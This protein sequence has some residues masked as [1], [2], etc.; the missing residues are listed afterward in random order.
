VS[1]L[2]A[3][4]VCLLGWS[5]GPSGAGRA[6]EQEASD[7]GQ[8]TITVAGD[9]LPESSWQGPNNAA[10]LFDGVREEFQRAD[11]VFVNLEEP[12][13]RS[14]QV[15]PYKS[16]AAVKA[17][18][19]YVLHAQN[20][21][22]FGIFKDSGI[23]LV[24][25]AN[26]HM[27]DYTTGGLEDTL[28]GFDRVGMPVVGAG[29]KRQAE[30][31]YVFRKNGVRVALLA[32]TDVVP[33]HYEAT[34]IRPGIASSKKLSDLVEAIWRARR[35]ADFVVLMIHWGGQ[36]NHLITRRQHELARVAVKAGCNVVVGMH[37]HV[38]Q[39][40]EY[41]SG[42]PVFYSIGNFAFPSSNPAA[43]E[44]MMVKLTISRERLEKLEIIPVDISPE[45][46][47]SV[48]SGGRGEEILSHLDQFCRMFNTRIQEGR[49]DRSSI[50][51]DLV[52]DSK[53]HPAK[54][55]GTQR[56]KQA[57]AS[58]ASSEP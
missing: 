29:R 11:L 38:M 57:I 19:D 36:G 31:A 12:I 24:G 40:V 21:K 55:R 4:L 42:H 30:S 46:A 54:A 33:H 23:G 6:Q 48:A 35:Q 41:V 51:K 37:P 34:A 13:T 17:G 2:L 3:A 50:R 49:I 45:G 39:G 56:R 15:T 1:A 20:P 10:R 53:G 47:P 58:K 43:R 32:F 8:V 9:V 26:N 25:L 14:K 44:C 22:L 18:L 27:V 16:K 52:F 28:E 7:S 5:A